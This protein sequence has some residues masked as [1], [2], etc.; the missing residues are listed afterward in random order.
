M[1]MRYIL[2]VVVATA[3]A[4][5]QMVATGGTGSGAVAFGD[6]PEDMHPP[7]A[8]TL[9]ENIET[10][11]NAAYAYYQIL[12]KHAV[13]LARDNKTATLLQQ[14]IGYKYTNAKRLI[15]YAGS[16]GETPNPDP[17][18]PIN[19]SQCDTPARCW[20]LSL[21][22]ERELYKALTRLYTTAGNHDD[23]DMKALAGSLVRDEM[24]S[25]MEVKRILR[26]SGR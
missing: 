14:V 19:L 12:T 21:T 10:Q 22:L 6:G 9:E 25:I 15:M 3:F 4:Q 13:Y 23:V 8:R 20:E 2:F 17:P 5:G 1:F 26:R 7:V 16:R 18:Q 11:M 24:R